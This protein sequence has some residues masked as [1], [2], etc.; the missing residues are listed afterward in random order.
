MWML[1]APLRRHVSNRSFED[2]QQRLLNAFTR[3]V[4][5]DRWI[6][7]LAA[8]FIDLIYIDDSGLGALH[9]PVRILKQSQDNVFYIFAHIPG[10]GQGGRV[11]DGERHVENAGQRL[12]QQRFS[13]TGGADKKNVR[14]RQLDFTAALL[15]HLD[16]LVVVVDGDGQFL[17]GRVL[18]DYILIQVFFQFERAREFARAAIALLVPIV[19]NNGI[20]NCNA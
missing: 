3:N 1:A 11:Y 6:L 18:P 12:R 17:F 10:F 5:R 15:V 16:P 20:T 2:F 19:F 7:V 4:S 14:F 13:G 8:D 9:I